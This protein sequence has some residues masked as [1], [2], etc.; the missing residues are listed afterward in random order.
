MVPSALVN[1]CRVTPPGISRPNG[2]G[3]VRKNPAFSRGLARPDTP[4]RDG[5]R[6]DGR[7]AYGRASPAPLRLKPERIPLAQSAG[8]P[9]AL[10]LQSQT[11]IT[12]GI[13]VGYP[14]RA[15]LWRPSDAG[16]V[17]P[18]VKPS[19]VRNAQKDS[20]FIRLRSVRQRRP[21]VRPCHG[22]QLHR[23]HGGQREFGQSPPQCRICL[24]HGREVLAGRGRHPVPRHRDGIPPC[25]AVH[26]HR[27]MGAALRR[28]R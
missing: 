1:D 14:D 17:G 19:T 2:H 6:W 22:S 28:R 18:R 15:G 24:D 21:H 13:R 27:G 9:G 5:Y 11:A 10:A 20:D 25:V 8:V 12:G 26:R 4:A 16:P 7:P 3:G 23:S